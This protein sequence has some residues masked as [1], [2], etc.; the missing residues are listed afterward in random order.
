MKKIGRK[1]LSSLLACLIVFTCVA[2]VGTVT[3]SAAVDPE[4]LDDVDYFGE[5]ICDYMDEFLAQWCN[6]FFV[7]KL[8]FSLGDD[9][10]V[11]VDPQLLDYGFLDHICQVLNDSLYFGSGITLNNLY[12]KTGIVFLVHLGGYCFYDLEAWAD[13]GSVMYYDFSIDEHYAALNSWI[14]NINMCTI[15]VWQFGGEFYNFTKYIQ[16]RW[17]NIYP[18]NY[19]IFCIYRDPIILSDDGIMF[20]YFDSIGGGFHEC[21]DAPGATYQ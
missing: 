14:G 6:R 19:P 10:V 2:S 12:E 18:G 16:N 4:Y 13:T 11:F 20:E 1:L 8:Q 5:N 21:Y 17:N 3:A 7:S 9:T 15:G